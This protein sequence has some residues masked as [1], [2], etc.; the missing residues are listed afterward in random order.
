[1]KGDVIGELKR[2]FNPEFL[3]RVDETVV[4]HPLRE[5]HLN[6]IIDNLV[7]DLNERLEEKGIQLEISADVKRWLMKE[8]YQPA[9]GARP[10]RRAIQKNIE[11]PLSEELIKGRFKD[12][13]KVKVVIRD[14]MPVFME[15]EALAEV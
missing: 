7:R 4:F 15:E 6:Q 12:Y 14:N 5:E 2:M 11:D 10:M 13:K 9:Y 8:G 3:N 1:M